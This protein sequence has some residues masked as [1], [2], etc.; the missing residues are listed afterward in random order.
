M[1]VF[2]L[3]LS[4]ASFMGIRR[5]L[6]IFKSLEA[7]VP[8][9]GSFCLLC[10]LDPSLVL[11]CRHRGPCPTMVPIYTQGTAMPTRPS[12][13]WGL[14]G[15]PCPG[16][17]ALSGQSATRGLGDTGQALNIRF[18]LLTSDPALQAAW[19]FEGLPFYEG[20]CGGQ[21]G[22]ENCRA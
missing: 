10:W 5:Q 19:A 18:T 21:G 15:E 2:S 11:P 13:A 4:K 22:F 12:G 14:H 3:P 20:F 17:Q 16:P 7:A 6:S 8:R 1:S 9:R